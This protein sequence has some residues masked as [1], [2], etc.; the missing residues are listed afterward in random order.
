[1][2]DPILPDL[3]FLLDASQISLEDLELASLNRA[4][5]LGKQ[6]RQNLDHWVEQRAAAAVARWMIEH[7]DELLATQP[8]KIIKADLQEYFAPKRKK[9]A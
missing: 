7:R 9:S 8:K 3:D 2:R 6:I 4:D 5:S 1:M